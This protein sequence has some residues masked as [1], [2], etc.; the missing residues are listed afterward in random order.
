MEKFIRDESNSRN[1]KVDLSVTVPHGSGRALK[2]DLKIPP[3]YQSQLSYQRA[4]SS[5][6]NRDADSA[7]E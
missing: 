4:Q 2:T 5:D 3:S 1:A 6:S 7:K